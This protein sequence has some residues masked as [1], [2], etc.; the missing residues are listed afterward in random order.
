MS[1]FDI[2]ALQFAFFFVSFRDSEKYV[3][4]NIEVFD[5]IQSPFS[6]VG[7]PEVNQY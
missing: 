6:G 1:I 5:S 3:Y 4:A 2:Y 7:C